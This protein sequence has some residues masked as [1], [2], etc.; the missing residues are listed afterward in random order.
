MGLNTVTLAAVNWGDVY[1]PRFGERWLAS[2]LRCNPAPDRIY[3]ATDKLIEGL[4]EQVTQIISDGRFLGLNEIARQCGT[5][6]LLFTGLDDEL[7]P[8]AFADIHG[9]EDAITFGC[10]QAGESTALAFPAG[11][12]A[13]RICWQLG[14][15]PMNGGAIYR[16]S[17]VMEIPFRDYIYFDEV[18]WAEWAYFGKRVKFDNRVRLIWH[19]WSGANSW[20]ANQAGESQAKE[21]KRRLRDG[22]IKKGVPE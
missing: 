21:F 13:Y 7:P 8:D 15:N 9:D 5:T 18:F 22:L 4:P 3:I 6:W 12:D 20:P 2:L 19:R 11:E 17:S 14:Y 10:Q 16:C 1:W